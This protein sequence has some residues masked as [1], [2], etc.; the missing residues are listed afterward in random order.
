M[1]VVSTPLSTPS[2]HNKVITPSDT[3]KYDP[4]FRALYVGTGGDVS[5]T[6]TKGS[7]TVWKNV[8]DGFYVLS[9]GIRVNT[10]TTTADIIG[11][12]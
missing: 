4:P 8:P 9:S 1:S 11:L 5:L 3:T 6:D 10:E 7:T 12:F 2:K